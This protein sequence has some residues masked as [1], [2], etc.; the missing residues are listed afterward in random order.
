MKIS[1]VNSKEID[2]FLFNHRFNGCTSFKNEDGDRNVAWV[3]NVTGESIN[4]IYNTS[5]IET[6]ND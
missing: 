3:D 2:S 5:P 4:I 1:I 6:D